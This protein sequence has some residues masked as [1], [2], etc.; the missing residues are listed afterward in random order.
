MLNPIYWQFPESLWPPIN[1][2]E[3]LERVRVGYDI[4]RGSSVTICGLARNLGNKV[5]YLHGRLDCLASLFN[6]VSICIYTNDNDDSTLS[7]LECMKARMYNY[8]GIKVNIISERLYKEFH[9]S[10]TTQER[11]KDMAYYRNHYLTYL[12]YE[13]DS[14]YLIVL[15]TDIIGGYSWDGLAH[16]FSYIDSSI[17]CIGSNSLIYENRESGPIRL[18]YDAL[19]F[20]RLNSTKPHNQSEINLLCYNRGETLLEVQSAFGGLAIYNVEPIRKF[21]L[22]YDHSDCDHVTLNKKL[23]ELGY[24]NYMNPSMIVLYSDS[25]YSRKS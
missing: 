3:Y 6:E 11:Y 22:N 5:K 2:T 7:E 20:R 1:P 24:R 9:G 12:R 18:Y 13:T 8:G 17:G 21:N 14:K 15:D 23:V 25:L 16:S 4:M 19:A 10:V